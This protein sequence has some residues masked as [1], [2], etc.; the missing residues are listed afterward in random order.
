MPLL[1]LLFLFYFGLFSYLGINVSAF[2]VGIL[3]LSLIRSAYQSQF[4][5]GA[6]LS[7]PDGQ[8]KAALSLG[9]SKQKAVVSIILPQALR[10]ALPGCSN[11]IIKY[12]SLAYM[13][14]C[15]ELTGKGK[16]LASA[17]FR[18][19]EVFLIVGAIYLILVYTDPILVF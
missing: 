16:I 2:T 13:V 7:L 10:R 3:V 6:V 4:I 9:M 1:V 17:S 15:I 12:S 8:M 5:R 14:T 18:Y 19:T 11:E